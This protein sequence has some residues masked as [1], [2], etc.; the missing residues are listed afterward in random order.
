V[1]WGWAFGAQLE[2][3]P[4]G[5]ESPIGL[6]LNLRENWRLGLEELHWRKWQVLNNQA[7][8]LKLLDG[9]LKHELALILAKSLFSDQRRLVRWKLRRYFEEL[10]REFSLEIPKM[11]ISIKTL[12]LANTTAAGGTTD[13]KG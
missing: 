9:V 3:N 11:D 10:A 5:F 4:E 2:V 13:G 12:E 1:A 8:I 6:A 7:D